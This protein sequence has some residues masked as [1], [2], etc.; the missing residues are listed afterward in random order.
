MSN[1]R[2]RSLENLQLWHEPHHHWVAGQVSE[3]IG[4]DSTSQRD[5][6]LHIKACARAGNRSKYPLRTVLQC[7]QRRVNKGTAVQFLPR[8]IY[9]GPQ[10]LI[11]KWASVVQDGRHDW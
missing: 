3:P 5:H 2:R 11:Y 10:P 6:E 7:A 1:Y 8:K 9:R 4:I